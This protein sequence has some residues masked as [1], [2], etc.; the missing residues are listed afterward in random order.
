MGRTETVKK[1]WLLIALVLVLSLLIAPSAQAQTTVITDEAA[2]IQGED[3]DT[4]IVKANA[5]HIE[6]CTINRL[7]AY[8]PGSLG[9]SIEKCDV[10]WLD[11]RGAVDFAIIDSTLGYAYIHGGN[12]SL[13]TQDV[14]NGRMVVNGALTMAGE[15]FHLYGVEMHGPIYVHANHVRITSL[16]MRLE[17]W[18]RRCLLQGWGSDVVVE[19]FTSWGGY[20]LIGFVG[21]DWSVSNGYHH[22]QRMLF[23]GPQRYPWGYP[24]GAGVFGPGM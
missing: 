13:Q 6:D 15:V 9:L 23:F 24:I 1:W 7:I 2:V 8:R 3:F 14:I 22:G 20:A 17:D 5:V 11:V 4:L 12:V 10:G 16:S 21:R 19:G 18:D